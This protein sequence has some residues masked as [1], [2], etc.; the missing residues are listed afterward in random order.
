MVYLLQDYHKG[1]DYVAKG[2]DYNIKSMIVSI[3]IISN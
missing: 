1:D 3:Q 2:E